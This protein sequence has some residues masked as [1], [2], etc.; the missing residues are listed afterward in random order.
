MICCVAESRIAHVRLNRQALK[1]PGR[2]DHLP[3]RASVN[4]CVVM[5]Y[6]LGHFPANPADNNLK[7][8]AGHTI[9]R[10]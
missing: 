2:E 3:R 7:S 4:G 5:R 6:A 10:V 8:F 9:I 1:W